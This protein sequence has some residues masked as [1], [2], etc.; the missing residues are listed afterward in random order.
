MNLT[1][2]PDSICTLKQLR[3]FN[4]SHTAIK[5]LPES[6]C[7]LYNLQTLLLSCCRSLIEL[8]ANMGWLVNFRHLDISETNVI[9]MPL[10][11][12]RLK[13]LQTLTSFIMD[14]K[15]GSGI[16]EL[17]ELRQLKGSLSVL[18]LENVVDARD[19]FE[20]NLRDKLQLNESVLK[21]GWGYK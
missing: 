3:Y 2:L 13:S 11:L 5:V 17:R 4:L 8:P 9:E 1:E 14:K 21:W 15:G 18:K 12:G 7:T 10:Q 16:K 19:A 6:V 20:A